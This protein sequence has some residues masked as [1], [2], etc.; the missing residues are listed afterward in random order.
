V[1]HHQNGFVGSRVLKLNVGFLLASGPG[2]QHQTELGIPAI[3]V[4][5]DVDLDYLRGPLRLTRSKEGILVQG[6]LLAAFEGECTRCA[7]VLQRELALEVEELFAYPE[8][9]GSEFSISEDA[10]L[11]LTP[12]IRAEV[13]IAE[14]HGVLCHEGC[15]GLCAECGANLNR[16][17]CTCTDEQIDPRLLKLKELRDR[18]G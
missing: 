13:L 9:H 1:K 10:I 8:P 17:A 4:S 3:R 11:D 12:L 7:D 16:E 14:T 2:Q 5:D 18:I 15:K 6:E